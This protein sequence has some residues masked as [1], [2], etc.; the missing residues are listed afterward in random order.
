M[1]TKHLKSSATK[2][3]QQKLE[4]RRISK[5]LYRFVDLSLTSSTAGEVKV[6]HIFIVKSTLDLFRE[7]INHNENVTHTNRPDRFNV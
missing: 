4:N 5:I 7:G 6:K 3:Q 1:S 2:R